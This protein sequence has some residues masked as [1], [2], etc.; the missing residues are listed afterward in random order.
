MPTKTP[1]LTLPSSEQVTAASTIDFAGISYSDNFAAGNPGQL[2][3]GISDSNGTLSATDSAGVVPGSGTDSIGL[4]VSYSDLEA[5]LSSLSYTAAATSGS[6][7]IS[8]DI[9]DQAGVQ[10]TGTIPVTVGNSTT[11]TETWTGAVSNDW[12]TPGNWSGG[13]VPMRGDNVIIPSGTP[14]T[15]TLSDATLTGET[16]TVSGSATVNFTDVTL[17]F[18]P[19]N[20]RH[21][22]YR[23]RRHT[24]HRRAGHAGTGG[25]RFPVH[26]Q[27]WLRG[28]HRQQRRHRGTHRC[29]AD[30]R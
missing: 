18:D 17:D 1:E 2:F 25:E 16:I 8:F 26:Q 11:T 23:H 5:I 9:W 12:N 6:D 7:S 15:A 30:L 4:S 14:N 24:D 21:R 10:T 27:R 3:L 22:Q 29:A 20:C 19:A 28:A 13:A